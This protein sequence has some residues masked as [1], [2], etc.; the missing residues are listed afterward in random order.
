MDSG[1]E[2]KLAF[3]LGKGGLLGLRFRIE[4]REDPTFP[5]GVS[6]GE[7]DLERPWGGVSRL[8]QSLPARLSSVCIPGEDH[9]IGTSAR[10]S[11]KEKGFPSHGSIQSPRLSPKVPV[12]PEMF[13][14]LGDPMPLKMA[15]FLFEAPPFSMQL[16]ALG[17][18]PIDLFTEDPIR[19]SGGHAPVVRSLADDGKGKGSG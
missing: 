7:H 9:C 17:F 16:K 18:D 15:V 1:I 5:L 2:A 13:G 11:K 8:A 3:Q 6:D 14:E 10:S 19:E 12:R 4:S